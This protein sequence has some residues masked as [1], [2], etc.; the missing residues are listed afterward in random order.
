MR[1]SSKSRNRSKNS[2]RRGYNGGNIINRVFES[3][4]PEGKVR[5]TPQQIID[6]YISLTHDS[7]LSGDRVSAENFQQ[8]AEHYARIL[9]EAQKEFA[10]KQVDTLNSNSMPASRSPVNSLSGSDQKRAPEFGQSSVDNRAQINVDM[11]V[12][13]PEDNDCISNQ[14]TSKKSLIQKSQSNVSRSVVKNEKNTDKS[15]TSEFD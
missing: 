3:A 4:G 6:K 11:K 7:Q 5:G 12:S 15:V 1:P 2:N 10:E 13:A 14:E 8:H 9:A